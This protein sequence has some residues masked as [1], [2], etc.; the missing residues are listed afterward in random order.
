MV[1]GTV[2]WP[3]K[4]KPNHWM[5]LSAIGNRSHCR[6]DIRDEAPLRVSTPN[7]VGTKKYGGVE[8]VRFFELPLGYLTGGE[9]LK[10]V[11]EASIAM[12]RGDN[13]PG[14]RV[15][16]VWRAIHPRA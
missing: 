13:E 14:Q 2:R 1:F 4:P 5:L 9:M 10:T 3:G 11:I 12:V 15:C 8:E 16:S 7:D 6:F